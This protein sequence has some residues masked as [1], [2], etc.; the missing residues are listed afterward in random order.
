MQPTTDVN[1]QQLYLSTNPL[2]AKV[3]LLINRQTSTSTSDASISVI[4][5][6]YVVRKIHLRMW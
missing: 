5:D 1:L 2:T 3:Y 6:P 4:L